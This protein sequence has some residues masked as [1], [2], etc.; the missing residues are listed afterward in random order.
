MH[1]ASPNEYQLN[2]KEFEKV[3]RC[4]SKKFDNIAEDFFIE[5]FEFETYDYDNLIDMIKDNKDFFN[6]RGYKI[7]TIKNMSEKELIT[8]LLPLKEKIAKEKFLEYHYYDDEYKLKYKTTDYLDSLG[9]NYFSEFYDDK[10]IIDELI[11]NLEK[12][13]L[14]KLTDI[15]DFDKLKKMLFDELTYHEKYDYYVDDI[16]YNE[17]I[18]DEIIKY[19]KKN[20]LKIIKKCDDLCT[21]DYDFQKE[22]I[23]QVDKEDIPQLLKIFDDKCGLNDKIE[24]EYSDYTYLISM[25][26]FNI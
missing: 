19:D 9:Y 23:E 24:K 14:L 5:G 8:I 7:T 17:T 1:I 15:I 4:F 13:N 10:T 12:N 20:I 2:E 11:P 22:Y 21:N 6:K 18:I 16:C 3:K 25:G 26:K